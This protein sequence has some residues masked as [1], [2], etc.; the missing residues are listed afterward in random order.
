MRVFCD[1]LYDVSNM[2]PHVEIKKPHIPTFNFEERYFLL[3]YC[4][5]NSFGVSVQLFYILTLDL[6]VLVVGAAI[7][8]TFRCIQRP[9][10]T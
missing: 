4:G 3:S 6:C 10:D 9:I 8:S 1:K 5:D 2:R 7:Y